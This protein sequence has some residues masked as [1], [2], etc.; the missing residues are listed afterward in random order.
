MNDPQD[1]LYTNS[2]VNT[3]IINQK[4]INKET[5]NYDRFINYQGNQN[6]EDT[7][8]TLKYINNDD[9]ET[10]LVNIQQ[11][12][13]QPFPINNNKNNYPLF[14]PLLKDLSKNV[15]TKLKDV[16][17]NVDTGFRNPIFYPNSSNL[18]VNIPNSINNIHQ[19]EISNINIPNFLK[20]VTSMRNNFSWQYFNDYYINTDISYNILPFPDQLGRRFYGYNDI[21]YSSYIIP[22]NTLRE[23]P[24]FDPSSFLTYQANIQPGNYTIDELTREISKETS[25]ILH[26]ND[27]TILLQKKNE[28]V[29]NVSE[30]P[31][32]SFPY[33]ND[34]THLWKFEINK[35]NGAVYSVNRME[36]VEVFSIQT[37]LN[38][39]EPLDPEYFKKYDLFSDYSSLGKDYTLDS[40]YIYIT[41]PLI[42][43]KT[44]QWFDNS[45]NASDKNMYPGNP[46]N[47]PF[48]INPFPLVLSIDLDINDKQYI[49]NVL[50]QF[51]MT[52]F[53]D[54][55]IYTDSPFGQYYTEDEMKNI[56]YYKISDII[57]IPNL[58]LNL[59][60]LALRWSPVSS[61]GVPHQ[62]SI[63]KPDYGYFKPANNYTSLFGES[64]INYFNY[65]NLTN[66]L[67]ATSNSKIDI[68]RALCCR[69]IYGKERSVY[70]HYKTENIYETKRSVCE[71]FDFSIANSTNGDIR[72]IFNRGFGFIHSNLYGSPLNLENPINQFVES[73]SFYNTKNI[74]LSLKIENNNFYLKNNN[75]IFLKIIFPGIDLSK[76]QQNQNQVAFSENQFHVNQN[77][78]KNELI[79]YLGIGES[80]DC[81]QQLFQI[82]KKNFDG[83]FC[84][85]FTSTIPGDINLNDNNISSKIIFNAYENLI[86]GVSSIKI[87]ILDSELREINTQENYSFDLKFIFGDTK[88][89]ETDINTI[90]NKIDLVGKNY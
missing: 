28:N 44:D 20:S 9:D 15:Y 4:S 40:K 16:V 66:T 37:F 87:K 82:K 3:D 34:S 22:F 62:N 60:R 31:Y 45:S 35:Q 43:F 70:Q 26:A 53:Y 7:N 8:N 6:T 74:D 36:E 24:T 11:S 90:T 48:E 33:M 2:F 46:Y 85:I 14:D 10:D 32:H 58:N 49:T 50:S 29:N 38:Y 69:L 65:N 54:L 72:N 42:Q 51:T 79:N 68:G 89:K 17:V 25:K 56:S 57:T 18:S 1:L 55:R 86:N 27:K 81:Y 39:S 5:E 61:K 12:N 47:N 80:I 78:T 84:K 52:T 63:P 59:V 76:I 64:L 83:I 41:I 71:Y 21:P 73:L 23:D 77:Y 75:Y 13:F 19:I 30:E 67:Y 88:L